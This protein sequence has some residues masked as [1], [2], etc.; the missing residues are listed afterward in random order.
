METYEPGNCRRHQSQLNT[1]TAFMKKYC[2]LL[3]SMLCLILVRAQDSAGLKLPIDYLSQITSKA[4]AIEGK[5]DKKTEKVLSQLQKNEEKI[6][7]KLSRIDSLKASQ[8]FGDAKEKYSSLKRKLN[9]PGGKLTQYMPY[10]DTL[11]TSLKFLEQNK[12]LL[13]DAKEL[14]QKLSGAT[15][16]IKAMESSFAKAEEVKAFIRERKRYLKEQLRNMPF[17]KQL[18]KLNKQ[19]YYYSAQVNDYKETFKDSKKMERKAVELLSKTKPFQD[20]MRK[21]SELASLFRLPGGGDDLSSSVSLQGLQTRAQVNQMIQSRLGTGANAQALFQQN[22]QGAQAQLAQ[23]KDKVSQYAQGSYGNSGEDMEVPDFKP[24]NQKTKSFL[25][26]LEYGGNVQSQKARYFFPVTSDIGLSLGY[27][28]NDKSVIGVGASYKLGLG[29]GWKQISIS[30]EGVGLRSYVDY[31]IKGSIFLSGGYEQ[32]YRTAFASIEELKDQ[33]TWQSSGLIG[34][35]KKYSVS[36]KLKG[37]IQLLWD[38]LSYQ[39]V[40]KT[41]AVLFRVGY[42]LK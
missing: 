37:N 41:Q 33:S 23:L 34:L 1:V 28:L 25:D 35:S 16:K 4:E 39:Q 13:K 36:K 17:T 15:N 20:F 8:V 18:T 7:R 26:R 31:K 38:F 11:K 5:L 19:A 30:H 42:N 6:R 2:L 14:D 29:K 22:V 12:G 24:N 32:N 9:N 3:L 40:P 27:K 21:N 10:L